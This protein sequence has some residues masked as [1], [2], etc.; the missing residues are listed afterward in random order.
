M[1]SAEVQLKFLTV[2]EVANIFFQKIS[3]VNLLHL[4]QNKIIQV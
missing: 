3:D 2:F 4:F 1:S